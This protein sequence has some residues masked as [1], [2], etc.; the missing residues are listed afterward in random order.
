MLIVSKHL[1]Y[2]FFSQ[3]FLVYFFYFA[4]L[5]V[6]Y[7]VCA[8]VVIIRHYRRHMGSGASALAAPTELS[9]TAAVESHSEAEPHS[10]GKPASA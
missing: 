10:N 4:L 7:M 5:T 9:P 3:Q 1:Y 2:I 8:T 6:I